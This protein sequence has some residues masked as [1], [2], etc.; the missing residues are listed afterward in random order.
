MAGADPD[1]RTDERTATDVRLLHTLFELQ[2]GRTPNAIA[3]EVPPRR[4]GETRERFTYAE[5]DGRADELAGRLAAWVDRECVVAVLLPRAGVELWAAQLAILKA[6][7]AWTCIEPDT[8]AERLRFLLEDSRAVAVV[9][10]EDQRSRLRAVGFPEERIVPPVMAR[11]ASPQGRRAAG[12]APPP[13]EWLGPGTLAYVI[14]TSGTTGRPKG[15]MIEHRSA[16]NLVRSDST[17]FGLGPG[18][19]VAQTSSASYDSSVEEVW[20]AW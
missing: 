8:P 2:A 13:P 3:L 18:D 15:V 1:M 7:A 12:G 4:A 16:A 10:G 9:A 19:R 6:G 11:E 17:Y 5:L 14:Y 20:L